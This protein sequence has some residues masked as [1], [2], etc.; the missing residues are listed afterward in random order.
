MKVLLAIVVALFAGT[1]YAEDISFHMLNKR[2]D[3]AKMVYS[4]DVAH[5]E[6]GDTVTWL[7]N[8]AKRTQC[9]IYCRSRWLGSNQKK[10]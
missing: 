5:V 6:V 9:R 7:P 3:G 10:S 4:E 8:T 1:A 2:D